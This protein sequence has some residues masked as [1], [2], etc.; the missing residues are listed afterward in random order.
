MQLCVGFVIPTES[1]LP[2]TFVVP[3]HHLNK[4]CKNKP[5]HVK[6]ESSLFGSRGRGAGHEEMG[7]L[8]STKAS[9]TNHY[10][11]HKRTSKLLNTAIML[12]KPESDQE[13]VASAGWLARERVMN[14]AECDAEDDE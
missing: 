8:E 13:C 7:I 4:Q 14:R 9:N 12:S 10:N 11:Q 3:P 5:R 2:I 6:H 1:S